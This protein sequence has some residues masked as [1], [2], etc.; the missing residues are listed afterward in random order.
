M[1]LQRPV[2]NQLFA[3]D[4]E[5]HYAS[6]ETVAETATMSDEDVRGVVRRVVQQEF[7]DRLAASKS[8]ETN[9]AADHND[10][11]MDDGADFFALGMDSLQS[12]LVR[13]RLLRQIPLP[14][15]QRMATNVVFEYPSVKLLSEH[16]LL[17]RQ[18]GSIP[19]STIEREPETVAK[20]MVEKYRDLI[21]S[22]D[23]QSPSVSV[24]SPAKENGVQGHVIVSFQF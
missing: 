18:K 19:E 11:Q 23:V 6:R 16:I 24:S 4:I 20:S 3:D 13:R 5:A 2:L 22:A 21:E 9:G 17:L 15:E 1:T 8:G 10:F 14:G 7:Q 12:S